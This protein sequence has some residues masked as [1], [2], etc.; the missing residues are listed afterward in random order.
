MQEVDRLVYDSRVRELGLLL[1]CE[2]SVEKEGVGDLAGLR[3]EVCRVE[4]ESAEG[5]VGGVVTS[6]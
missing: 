2:R 5:V 1:G 4:N 3:V 6:A